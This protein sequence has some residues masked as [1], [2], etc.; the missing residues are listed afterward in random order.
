MPNRKEHALVVGGGLV[1]SLL[2]VL[3]AKRG[4][5]VSV[6]ERRPDIRQTVLAAG[7]SINL[8]LSDRGWKALALADMEDEIRQIAIPM[9]S[10]CMHD[11]AGNIT[12]QAYGKE[13]EAIY[14]VSRGGLNKALL[15]KAA[16]YH[17]V[18]LRF[19]KRCLDVD[20]DGCKLVFE[21]TQ[22]GIHEE[23]YTDRIYATD[24]AF[25]AVRQRLQRIDR[26]DYSQTYMTHGYKELI[27]PALSDGT[28]RIDKH[29]LHIW[30]RGKFM[31][32]ALANLDGSFTVTL[33]FPFEGDTSFE[34]IKTAKDVQRF[35]TDTFPDAVA[36]MPTLSTDYFENPTS[37]LCIIRCAPWNY[38][39]KVLLMGDAA[40]AIVPF[41]GQG[42]N[43]GFEDC[44]EFW[45][46]S[47]T[48]G[49]DAAQIFPEF[50]RIRKPN[51]DAIAELAL[52]NYT[53]MRDLVADE[54]FL[55]RKKIEKKVFELHPD[56]WVPLYSMVTFSHTPYAD[57]LK[58]GQ[59][60]ERIM[61]EIMAR[62]D[63]KFVWDNHNI[64]DEILKKL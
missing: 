26:F 62:N 7:R 28:H 44:S 24:G 42:M 34:S 52:K 45:R 48:Y 5:S 10:R 29:A 39:D 4:F 21:D 13:G 64:I 54:M 43:A 51:G 41:Y 27:I 55:L 57:A 6:Y 9:Y 33:F 23:V 19:N 11:K 18:S 38:R 59:R 50:A 47:E 2:A 1:G 60:Q 37:S 32:I 17:N 15:L 14:S 36:L 8:A 12:Y 46:L 35:F 56:K 49:D 31:L 53:E 30:P 16:K 25:S 61:D 20:P 63:I 58:I 40:H 22:T 3:L